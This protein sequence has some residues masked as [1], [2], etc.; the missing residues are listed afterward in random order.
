MAERTFPGEDEVSAYRKKWD[1]ADKSV[2]KHQDRVTDLHAEQTRDRE[3]LDR[4]LSTDPPLSESDL[5]RIREE[6]TRLWVRLRPRLSAERQP[7][8]EAGL[9]VDEFEN[10]VTSADQAVDCIRREAERLT[11]RKRLEADARQTA[12]RLAEAQN[13][14]NEAIG[15][16]SSLDTEWAGLWSPSGIP[17]P[18]MDAARDLLAAVGRL[19]ELTDESDDLSSSLSAD[20]AV[21][22]EHV[23]RLREA[24]GET[25]AAPAEAATLAELTALAT[26]QRDLLTKQIGDR[27]KA[28]AI[29]KRL[30]DDVSDSE[31]EVINL[32][33]SSTTA[34]RNG[35]SCLPSTGCRGSR[36]RSRRRWPH[37][38]RQRNFT[39]KPKYELQTP[40]SRPP[41]S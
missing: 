5:T 25:G 41:S 27:D 40:S 21:A 33:E 37:S 29:A 1:A 30:R 7:E 34:G 35:S 14:L 20:R 2:A 8:L 3:A 38:I 24:V 12:G 9:P 32:Q 15:K 16:R 18:P 22:A 19:R 26:Q 4:F 31:Q 10:A 17:A 39:V 28:A 11:D 13:L 6:R 23:A 36:T